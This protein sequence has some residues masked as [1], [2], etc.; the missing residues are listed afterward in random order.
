MNG[1]E[2]KIKH[3]IYIFRNEESITED[4]KEAITKETKAGKKLHYIDMSGVSEGRNT[5]MEIARYIIVICN[6]YCLDCLL[7]Y[8]IDLVLYIIIYS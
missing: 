8:N 3:D 7:V 5:N 6:K 4:N 1:L 2:D